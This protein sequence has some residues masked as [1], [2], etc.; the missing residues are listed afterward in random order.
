[1]TITKTVRPCRHPWTD[2]QGWMG[3]D[4]IAQTPVEYAEDIR[5]MM[6]GGWTM[7]FGDADS[8][9]AYLIKKMEETN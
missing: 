1:M 9:T 2:E 7:L 3:C 4:I 5:L 8:K 6:D